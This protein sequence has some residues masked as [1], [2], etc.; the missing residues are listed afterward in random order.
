[1]VRG[2][3]REARQAVEAEASCRIAGQRARRAIWD[4][5]A[6]RIGQSE[7]VFVVPEGALHLVHFD[8]L[9]REEG[10]Y[11]IESRPAIHQL[12]AEKD[13]LSASREGARGKGLLAMGGAAFDRHITGRRA[14]VEPQPQVRSVTD[15]P[16]CPEF[17]AVRFAPLPNTD[18]EAKEVGR[19]F[20]R[21]EPDSVARGSALVLRG[22]QA[23]EA[24]FRKLAPGRR[25]LHLATHGFFLGEHCRPAEPASRGIGGLVSTTEMAAAPQTMDSPLRLA[26]LAL[27]GANQRATATGTADDGILTA[28]EIGL[29][30]LSGVEWAVLSA[31]DSGAGTV[32]IGE[33][34][35]GLRRAFLIAGARSVIMSLWGVDDAAGREWMRALY[36]A[37]LGRDLSTADAVREASL[38]ML[39]QRRARGQ[40]THPFY[41]AAF[42]AAGDWR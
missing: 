7:T 20:R 42:V 14:G 2:Y 26:G 18:A 22:D 36:D 17:Q 33:G 32:A 12:T 24:S 13:L 9:P 30:D 1:M 21:A 31:C 34:V 39:R 37:R 23:T 10:G 3:A 35:L 4:P 41:W 8:A 38:Q 40:T 25:I 19:L 28:E 29:L 16:I 11:L 27:A 6:T 5:V 15:R